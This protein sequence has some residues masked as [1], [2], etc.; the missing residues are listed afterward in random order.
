METVGVHDELDSSITVTALNKWQHTFNRLNR[1]EENISGL[2]AFTEVS[3]SS[4]VAEA[5]TGSTH[6]VFKG[7]EDCKSVSLA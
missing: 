4:M 2:L 5:Q 7:L 1:K 3:R 6:N